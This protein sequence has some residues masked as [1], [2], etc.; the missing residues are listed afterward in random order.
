MKNEYKSLAQLA[1]EESFKKRAKKAGGSLA[2]AAGR[3]LRGAGKFLAKTWT[4][5]SH[6]D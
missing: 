6:L 2:K 1:I 4:D 5:R 3:G